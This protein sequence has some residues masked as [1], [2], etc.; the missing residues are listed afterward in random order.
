[1]EYRTQSQQLRRQN[2]ATAAEFDR[3]QNDIAKQGEKLQRAEQSYN[4][5]YNNV[6]QVRGEEF[7]ESAENM[8][9]LA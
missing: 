5:S 4:A 7:D 6:R 2:E 9:I 8:D 3:F 1:M